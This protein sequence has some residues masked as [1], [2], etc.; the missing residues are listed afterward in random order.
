MVPLLTDAEL[1]KRKHNAR[2]HTVNA[3]AEAYPE[4]DDEPQQS[5]PEADIVQDAPIP[6]QSDFE[7]GNDSPADESAA[8]VPAPPSDIAQDVAISQSVNPKPSVQLDQQD[9]DDESFAAVRRPS[10]RAGSNTYFPI[11][12]G[13][14][15]GG[16]I[17]IANAFSNGKG[18]TAA[19]RATAYG[20]PAKKRVQ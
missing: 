5:E 7:F 1:I 16:A 19:S 4:G 11:T 15:N 17:A 9:D 12:F 10:E 20:N 8:D 6:E 18:G 2:L 14:T 3:V 13:S